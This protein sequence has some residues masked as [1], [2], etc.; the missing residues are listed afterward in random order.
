MLK[1]HPAAHTSSAL[2][3]KLRLFATSTDF[4]TNVQPLNWKSRDTIKQSMHTHTCI[5]SWQQI[6]RKESMHSGLLPETRLQLSINVFHRSLSMGIV[7]RGGLGLHGHYIRGRSDGESSEDLRRVVWAATDE[8]SL[9]WRHTVTSQWAT[10]ADVLAASR[11]ES[12]STRSASFKETNEKRKL[13]RK[14][15]VHGR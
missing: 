8:L 14:Y 3:N 2:K 11:S 4:Q 10:A 9:R 13:Y 5:N 12:H 1:L 6:K 7:R 15:N